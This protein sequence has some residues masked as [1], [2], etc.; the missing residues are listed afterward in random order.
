MN[1][2]NYLVLKNI[3]KVYDDGYVAVKDINISVNKGEFVTLLGP[4]GCGKTTI[5]KIISGFESPTS[6][7]VY[8]NDIDIQDMPINQRPTATVFQDYA[9]FP[10]MDVYHN[11]VYGLKAMLKILPIP[12]EAQQEINTIYEKAAIKAHYEIN[13]CNLSMQKAIRQRWKVDEKYKKY[14][15]IF[16]IQNIR[17]A[18]FELRNKFLLAKLKK[19][20]G[21]DATFKI[22]ASNRRRELN[23]LI[24]QR[25]FK[26]PVL[27]KY[28]YLGLNRWE[29]A[30]LE[31]RRWYFYKQLIDRKHDLLQNEI[32][33]LQKEISYW[34]NYPTYC[35]EAYLKQKYSR[36]LNAREIAAKAKHIIDL[37]G[38][39]G[40]EKKY[41]N[42]LS[43]GM[44]QRVALARALV[45]EPDILLL[46]E[47]LSALDYKVRQQMQLELKRIHKEV[48]ITFILVTHDQGE[49][50]SLSSKIVV[51]SKGSVEQIDTPKRIYD[52][53]KNDW[54]ASFVG[55]ANIFEGVYLKNKRVSFNNEEFNVKEELSKKMNPGQQV[56][57]IIRPEDIRI[58]EQNKG[59]I[60]ARVVESVYK[61]DTYSLRL[62]WKEHLILVET[63]ESLPQ[64]KVVGLD[65]FAEKVHIMT[66]KK[67][68]NPNEFKI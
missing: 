11:I 16:S 68:R 63:L 31:F 39:T 54:V 2:K 48:G 25:I 13:K 36:K 65:W 50:L 22:S 18:Q 67:K 23:A 37:V 58:V 12:D 32:N 15:Q 28:S 53:P 57:F 17:H 43:G 56:K 45:V 29:K 4:S 8:V 14:E 33:K 9:L 60:N 46:D 35:K 61:G 7:G 64:N 19:H 55:K 40:S 38:L 52:T 1:S 27:I 51:M 6:G 59:I 3:T 34:E 47:P 26:Q 66:E 41:P 42:E 44:Q 30:Y 24:R 5:L 62:K 49:A 20:C 21:E 10:N